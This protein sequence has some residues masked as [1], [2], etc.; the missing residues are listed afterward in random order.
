MSRKSWT[1]L[2][3]AALTVASAAAAF[4]WLPTDAEA[5]PAA[6]QVNQQMQQ[7][8]RQ[9]LQQQQRGNQIQMLVHE[10]SLFL[11]DREWLFKFDV[12]TLE[13]QA[14]HNLDLLRH[15]HMQKLQAEGKLPGQAGQ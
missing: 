15:N 3:L 2:T 14:L 10:D 6:P 11:A 7:M 8:M 9:M 4:A 5:Q 13:V 12:E 1:Y